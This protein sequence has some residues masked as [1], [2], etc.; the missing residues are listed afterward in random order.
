[1]R[2]G[3]IL[4][5]SGRRQDGFSLLVLVVSI[6]VLIAMVGL[7]VDLGRMFIVKTEL[8]AFADASA[9]AAI[10]ELDGSRS[11]LQ[12]AHNTATNGPIG[13]SRPNG[14]MFDTT[15]IWQVTHVY[16]QSLNGTYDDY[17]TASG[18]AANHYRFL[19]LTVRATMP[20]FFLPVITGIPMQQVQA[21]ATAGQ[22]AQTATFSSGGLVPFSPDAHNPAEH[23]N[24]GLTPGVQYTL[25]WGPKNRTAFP[26]DAGFVPGNAPSAHGFIDIGQG[27]ST[28]NLRLVI[29]FGG[30]PN[31]TSTPNHVSV[32]DILG[33]PGDR[34]VSIF[35]AT[36]ERSN[37]DPD[38]TSVTWQ[39]YKTTGIG[40]G[41]RLVTAAVNDPALAAGNGA[42]HTVTIIGFGNFLLDT[43][44]NIT[45]NSGSLCAT[46]IGPASLTSWSSGG[47]DGTAIYTA[48]LYQ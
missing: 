19:R 16:S 20:L 5:R 9:L 24:F 3:Q 4:R 42:N 14:W 43:A 48:M 26:G 38:Q 33:V 13:S 30:F 27:N 10:R 7:S 22:Q 21:M 8:Q 23:T 2:N 41:R 17:A 46:Y 31:A 36:A 35:T 39:D 29:V 25:K 6:V 28:N 47:T 45:G 12:M 37:Q 34:G 44:N 40:N 1:M 15:P 32:G 18:Q 11:G